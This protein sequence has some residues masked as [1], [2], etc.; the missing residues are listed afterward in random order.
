MRKYHIQYYS[1][2]KKKVHCKQRSRS[3]TEA[4]QKASLL[5]AIVQ[6]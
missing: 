5:V 6:Q 3:R 2:R 1:A 4:N